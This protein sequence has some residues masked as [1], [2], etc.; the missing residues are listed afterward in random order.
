[1]GDNGTFCWLSDYRSIH[2]TEPSV[3][4]EETP[5]EVH[6]KS[7][8]EIYFYEQLEKINRKAELLSQRKHYT[9]ANKAETL[10][11]NLKLKAKDYYLNRKDTEGFRNYCTEEIAT[12]RKELDKHRGWKKILGAL[13]HA[14]NFIIAAIKQKPVPRNLTFFRTKSA[15]LLDNLENALPDITSSWL[16]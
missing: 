8:E 16:P 11:Y 2:T 1:M 5:E 10:Y 14:V 7:R 12:A 13:E 3:P 4:V 15:Y 6:H 9:A